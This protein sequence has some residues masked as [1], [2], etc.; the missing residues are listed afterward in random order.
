MTKC[1]HCG[2]TDGHDYMCITLS[3]LTMPTEHI[4]DG[5]EG[6]ECLTAQIAAE[7]Q[8][9]NNAMC[10]CGDDRTHCQWPACGTFGRDWS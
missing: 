5:D 3:P 4:C 7:I 9:D 6:T 10:E 1:E 2:A 8:R